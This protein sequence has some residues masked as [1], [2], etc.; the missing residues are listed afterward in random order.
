MGRGKGEGRRKGGEKQ[1]EDLGGLFME[2]KEGRRKGRETLR[3]RGEDFEE[4]S[5]G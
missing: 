4:S 1:K 3:T 5:K 2:K